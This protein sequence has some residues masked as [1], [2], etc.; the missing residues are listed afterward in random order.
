MDIALMKLAWKSS[1]GFVSQEQ[2]E[3]KLLNI[4]FYTQVIF[5]S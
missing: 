2:A 5:A 4:L 3:V 1:C